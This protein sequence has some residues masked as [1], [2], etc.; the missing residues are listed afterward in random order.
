MQSE[1]ITC[2]RVATLTTC[3]N[4]QKDRTQRR[5]QT[6]LTSR[7]LSAVKKGLSECS[8]Q[9]SS[10]T[11]LEFPTVNA[12]CHVRA[13]RLDFTGNITPLL[14]LLSGSVKRGSSGMELIKN[15]EWCEHVWLFV[16]SVFCWQFDP[17]LNGMDVC[18][19]FRQP[20]WSWQDIW[21]RS[22]N[23][24]PDQALETIISHWPDRSVLTLGSAALA[25]NDGTLA[26]SKTFVMFIPF[27]YHFAALVKVQLSVDL[28]NLPSSP[29]EAQS[30]WLVSSLKVFLS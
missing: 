2:L 23:I 14:V 9:P 21:T 3:F 20:L 25:I 22:W 26:G 28:V 7:N 27:S 30:L 24:L 15:G 19:T 29:S 6:S 11:T 13:G 1:K 17:I 8:D 10:D 18:F 4:V 5:Q 12:R 16:E